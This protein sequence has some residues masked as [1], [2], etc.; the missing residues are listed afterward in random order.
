MKWVLILSFLFLP[1][2]F[3]DGINSGW[4][5]STNVDDAGT[6]SYGSGF[7]ASTTGGFSTGGTQTASRTSTSFTK[8][9]FSSYSGTS[10]WASN[11]NSGSS[12]YQVYGIQTS[13]FLITQPIQST[14]VQPIFTVDTACPT[15][16]QTVNWIF[17]QW[18]VAETTNLSNTYFLG[19]STIAATTGAATMTA[20]Y[21]V[22]GNQVFS[23]SY[24]MS[25]NP[26]S[27]G[28]ATSTGGGDLAGTL[29]YAADGT[30][31]YKTQPGNATFFFP[32]ASVTL[33]NLGG[34]TYSG[35]QFDSSSGSTNNTSVVQVTSNASGNMFTVIPYSNVDTGA[36]AS[37]FTDTISITAA[38]NPQNGMLLGSVTRTGTGPGAPR[39]SPVLR[40]SW[41][42]S[43]KSSAPGNRLVIATPLIV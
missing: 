7:S 1:Q 18:S 3:A 36:L 15:S 23:G 42:L 10:P 28:Q 13:D 4:S 39:K 5:L 22:G 35:I 12:Y 19:T 14:E 32:Q 25:L 8:F 43:L 38:N 2:A 30:G 9:T 20:Q 17:V 34:I 33:S 16:T 40:A 6:M 41:G 27:S 26:C 21:D 31:V 29:F 37:T 24:A 11:W